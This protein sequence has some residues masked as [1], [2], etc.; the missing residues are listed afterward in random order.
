MP[1]TTFSIPYIGLL[2]WRVTLFGLINS[3]SVFKRLIERVF[4]SLDQL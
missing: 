2:L 4:A 1:H 3:P